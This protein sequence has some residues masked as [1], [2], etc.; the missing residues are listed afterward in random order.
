MIDFYNR[1][2]RGCKTHNQFN[3]LHIDLENR[4]T[5]LEL[6]ALRSELSPARHTWETLFRGRQSTDPSPAQELW[7]QNLHRLAAKIGKPCPEPFLRH[8]LRRRVT[9]FSAGGNRSG[10]TLAIC[11]SG[12]A[13]RMMMPLPVFLQ[14]IASTQVDVA[15]MH[16]PT[17]NSYRLGIGGVADSLEASIDKLRDILR[18]EDYRSV[19]SIGTSG[20]GVP[21]VMCALRLNLDA[22]LSVGGN[23]PDDPRWITADGTGLREIFRRHVDAAKVKPAVFLAFGTDC[24]KDKKSAEALAS[25]VPARLITISVPN[26]SVE[27]NALY[28]VARNGGLAGLLESTVFNNSRASTQS[29]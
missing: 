2:V 15:F 19:V 16:D 13:Q 28:P 26:G 27:H 20:G 23:H 9:L 21:A 1:L 25:I 5:P 18:I 22:A 8:R 3:K 29:A 10:K 24:A 6:E 11:F 4:M 7:V 12:R 17:R 14:N